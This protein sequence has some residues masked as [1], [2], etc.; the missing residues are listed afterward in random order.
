MSL[1]KF[2]LN[3]GAPAQSALLEGWRKDPLSHPDLARM[4]GRELADL[5][6]SVAPPAPTAIN[7]A[8]P[9]TCSRP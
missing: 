7:V 8:R 3:P 1:L 4:S 9:S 5:P 6:L 2:F